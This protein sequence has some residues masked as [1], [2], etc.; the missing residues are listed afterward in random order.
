MR[1]DARIRYEQAVANYPKVAG[2]PMSAITEYV[3]ELEVRCARAEATV[4]RVT[5]AI[6][7]L[8]VVA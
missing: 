3:T 7:P 8:E 5:R 4:E 6:L 2:F 1:S